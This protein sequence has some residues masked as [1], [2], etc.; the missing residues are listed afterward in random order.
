M[1]IK[2]LDMYKHEGQTYH[3]GETRVVAEGFGTFLVK[4]GFA[5]DL[6]GVVPTGTRTGGPVRIKPEDMVTNLEG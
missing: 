3:P 4:H 6:D 2:I 5:E 1:K